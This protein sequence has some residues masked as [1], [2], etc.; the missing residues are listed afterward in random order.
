MGA[1]MTSDGMISRLAGEFR[2]LTLGGLAVIATGLS[3]N[4]FDADIWI[5]PFSSPED[6]AGRLAPSLYGAGPSDPVAI[7]SWKRVARENLAEV[8][9]RDGRPVRGGDS[10]AASGGLTTKRAKGH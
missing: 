8:I 3:R 5:E 10:A 7:G 4:T 9:G 6:W 2:V 1:E